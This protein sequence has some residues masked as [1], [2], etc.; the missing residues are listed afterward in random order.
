MRNK[1]FEK[2]FFDKIKNNWINVSS[3]FVSLPR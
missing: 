2:F 1:L 3:F